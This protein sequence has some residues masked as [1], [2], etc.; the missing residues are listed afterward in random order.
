MRIKCWGSRGSISV[1]GKA[2]NKYGGDTTCIEI[3]AQTGEKIIVDAGTGL[4]KMGQTLK[5]GRNS[6]YHMMFT[7]THWD[8]LAGFAFFKPLQDSGVTITINND[9]FFEKNIKSILED[10]MKPPV[11]P[12]T[13]KEMQAKIIYR[14]TSP[15]PFSVGSIDIETILLSHPGGGLGYRFMEKEKSFVFLTDNELGFKHPGSRKKNEYINFCKNADI[16]FHDSEFNPDEYPSKKGW[17][18]SSYTDA[19]D[20]A[21]RADVKSLGLFHINQE[22]T[23]DEMDEMVSRCRKIIQKKNNSMCCFGVAC[24]M[25]ITL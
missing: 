11:F 14:A 21:F 7:H 3:Q 22:R 18:H 17:G 24:E 5:P 19:L 13:M 4:R 15:E 25:E 20:L 12:I 10:I 8:H 1:S 9:I 2:Y 16:L 23:D 6:H